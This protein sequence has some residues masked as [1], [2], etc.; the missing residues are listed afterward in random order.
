M[1]VITMAMTTSTR[2][3]LYATAAISAALAFGPT[4]VVAQDLAA[5]TIT[6]PTTAAPP[7]QSPKIVLPPAP[8]VEIAAE[9]SPA[10]TE[11]TAPRTA[12]GSKPAPPRA[13]A[14]VPSAPPAEA[15]ARAEPSAT[16]AAAS[17]PVVPVAD[18]EPAPNAPV[19]EKLQPD[20]VRRAVDLPDELIAA[21]GLGVIGLG[22]AGLVGMRRRRERAALANTVYEPDPRDVAAP[23]V[24]AAERHSGPAVRQAATAKTSTVAHGPVPTGEAREAL[25]DRMVAAPPNE[26]NPFTSAK[27]RRKRA[28]IILQSLDRRTDVASS[29]PFDWR[30]YR[31]SAVSQAARPPMVDA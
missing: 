13:A 14:L 9:E 2:T 25:L 3:S 6:L 11:R 21:A 20:S 23:V 27:G 31:S 16:P 30:T 1:W 7:A 26:E 19:P 4:Q 5:Q 22:I 28:R 8:P 24:G 18:R 15:R 10:R 12:A 29:E 17:L